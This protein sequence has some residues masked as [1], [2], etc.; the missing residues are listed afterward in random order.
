MPCFYAN[1]ISLLSQ[2]KDAM[3]VQKVSST[4]R[5]IWHINYC[6]AL[7]HYV[8][9]LR[10]V[11]VF[12]CVVTGLLQPFVVGVYVK[13]WCKDGHGQQ[14]DHRSS[15]DRNDKWTIDH[16]LLAKWLHQLGK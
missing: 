16:V 6:S 13:K 10:A 4:R 15:R 9:C 5:F 7:S 12:L 2:E 8:H 1:A 3:F 11:A 14:N